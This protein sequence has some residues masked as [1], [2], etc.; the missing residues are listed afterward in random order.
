MSRRVFIGRAPNR[1]LLFE[2]G[3][4]NAFEDA[5]PITVCDTP[6]FTIPPM[7]TGES[8]MVMVRSGVRSGRAA[9]ILVTA[10]MLMTLERDLTR[11][12]EVSPRGERPLILSDLT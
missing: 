8:R 4:A 10:R 5:E 12:V 3:V 1:T 2:R 9:R 7:R 6:T 11:A